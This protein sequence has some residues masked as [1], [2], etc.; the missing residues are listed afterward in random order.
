MNTIIFPC[1]QEETV[2]PGQTVTAGFMNDFGEGGK[3]SQQLI[4][5]VLKIKDCF[6]FRNCYIRLLGPQQLV[7]KN[8]FILSLKT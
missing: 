1:G 2:V 4:N 3:E 7:Q 5:I 8:N 6:S